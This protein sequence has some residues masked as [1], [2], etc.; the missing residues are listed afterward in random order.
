MS[1]GLD[2]FGRQNVYKTISVCIFWSNEYEWQAAADFVV[3]SFEINLKSDWIGFSP[4]EAVRVNID[5]LSRYIEFAKN[6]RSVKF[7]KSSQVEAFQ[8]ERE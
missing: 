1:R 3:F 6:R 5:T 2:S 8:V 7:R 4:S